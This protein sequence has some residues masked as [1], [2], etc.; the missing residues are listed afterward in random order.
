MIGYIALLSTNGFKCSDGHGVVIL[1]NGTTSDRDTTCHICYASK[2]TFFSE[3]PNLPRVASDCVPWRAGGKLAI[4]D[5][6]NCVQNPVDAAWHQETAEIYGRYKIYRQSVVCD[7]KQFMPRSAKIFQ[8]IKPFLNVDK[9]GRL[10]DIGCANGEL[11]RYFTNIAPHWKMAGFEIDEKCRQEIENI[12]NVEAFYSGSLQ[13]ISQGFDLIT[14][15]HVFEHLPDPKKWLQDLK[16]LLNAGGLIL[17]QVPD[18]KQNPYNLLVADHCSHFL[19]SD[20]IRIAQDANYQIV[21]HS[22][23]WVKREL[24]LLLQPLPT[25]TAGKVTMSSPYLLFNDKSNTYPGNSLTWLQSI[26]DLANNF[27]KNKPCGIWGT[28]IAGTWLYSVL[29]NGADFFVD[30][31]ASRIGQQHLGKPILHPEDAPRGSN[32]FLALTPEIAA[33]IFNRWSHIKMAFHWPPPLTY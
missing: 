18:P 33:N 2:L 20:L 32:I 19:M 17:I 28:A 10:L 26:M 7:N 11:L 12:P 4:C 23:E 6:C 5:A 8:Q 15:M 27:A 25:T 30:E 22:K 31:D 29:E 14:L 13:K 1:M 21:A 9:P 16:P 24:S 3:Y